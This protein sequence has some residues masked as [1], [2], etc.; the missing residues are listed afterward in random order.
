VRTG[1][2]AGAFMQIPRRQSAF[3]PRGRSLHRLGLDPRRAR[4][5]IA[6][7]RRC[8]RGQRAGGVD[9]LDLVDLVAQARLVGRPSGDERSDD[10]MRSYSVPFVENRL[11]M[12]VEG[13]DFGFDSDFFHELTGERG[14]ERLADLDP[15]ARQAEMAKQGRARPADDERPALSK[16]GSRHRKDRAGGKQPV[17]HKQIYP[18]I[19]SEEARAVWEETALQDCARRFQKHTRFVQAVCPGAL[20]VMAGLVPAIHAAP[21]QR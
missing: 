9:P 20:A 8:R 13:E 18:A 5:N 6:Q 12:P 16:H 1:H 21:S 7:F 14:G 4:E 17:I 2:V 15:A 19:T 11:D 3:S 10:E